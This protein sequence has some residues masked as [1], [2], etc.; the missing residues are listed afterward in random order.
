MIRTERK[1]PPVTKNVHQGGSGD[2]RRTGAREDPVEIFSVKF[3]SEVRARWTH[4]QPRPLSSTVLYCT[5]PDR[6]R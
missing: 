6:G 5:V 3:S 2:G 1:E 4:G